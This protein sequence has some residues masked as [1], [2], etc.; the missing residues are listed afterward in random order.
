MKG[1]GW[2]Y[3]NGG[4]FQQSGDWFVSILPRLLWGRGVNAKVLAKPMAVDP[5]FWRI[6][7]RPENERLPLSFRANGAWV[8]RPPF[9]EGYIAL[10]ER[11]PEQ[12]ATAFLKWSSERLPEV[13][14]SSVAMLL[15]EIEGTGVRRKHFAALEICL[16]LLQDDWDGALDLCR[17]RGRHESGG[18]MTGSKTFFDQASEYIHAV[19]PTVSNLT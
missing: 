16:R 6:L 11:E 14:A 15:V 3:A 19:R 4:I 12:L 8:L 7:G 9:L 13:A 5:V 18:F 1:V 10:D 17:N 2:R